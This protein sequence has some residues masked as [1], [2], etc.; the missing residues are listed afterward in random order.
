[1]KNAMVY[2]REQKTGMVLGEGGQFS[3]PGEHSGLAA[4]SV[5]PLTYLCTSSSNRYGLHVAV[6]TS[7]DTV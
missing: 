6:W 2:M 7:S 1:M 5:A 4:V 3:G